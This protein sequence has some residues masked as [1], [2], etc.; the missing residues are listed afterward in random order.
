VPNDG[1]HRSWQQD[2]VRIEEQQYIA[3][4]FAIPNLECCDVALICLKYGSNPVTI[5]GNDLAGTVGR[6]VVDDNDFI[7]RTRLV[8]RAVDCQSDVPLVIVDRYDDA[9]LQRVSPR[10][11]ADAARGYQSMAG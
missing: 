7:S 6:A 5:P 10:K 4:R 2:I 1:L 11:F 9:D 3:C 8:Q